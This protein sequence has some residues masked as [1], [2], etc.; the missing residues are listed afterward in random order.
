MK[1]TVDFFK[2]LICHPVS[3]ATRYHSR[4]YSTGTATCGALLVA[5]PILILFGLGFWAGYVSKPCP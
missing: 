5:A 2:G 4:A 3:Y 1:A